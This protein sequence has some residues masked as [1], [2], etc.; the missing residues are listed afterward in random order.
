M[1]S[2]SAEAKFGT[3]IRLMCSVEFSRKMTNCCCFCDLPS[4]SRADKNHSTT[5]ALGRPK[6]CAGKTHAKHATSTPG[7]AE[8]ITSP[9]PSAPYPNP[10]DVQAT[11]LDDALYRTVY[12][13]V[14]IG[15]TIVECPCRLVLVSF[16]RR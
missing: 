12:R 14:L 3:K 2:A 7:K 6:T 4:R 15:V 1:S 9:Q 13:L 5:V 10:I 16:W 11:K 8:A